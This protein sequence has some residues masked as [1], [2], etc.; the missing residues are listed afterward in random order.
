MEEQNQELNEMRSESKRAWML[1]AIIVLALAVI[2]LVIWLMMMKTELK[3]LHSEKDYQKWQLERQ[4][5]SIVAEHEE[6]KEAYGQVSDSLAGM[7][8]TFQAQ[9]KEIKDL[10]NYKWEFYKV[11]KKLDRLQVVAQG[12][13]RRMDSIVVVNEQLTQENVEMKEEIK[14]AQR[15]YRNLEEEKGELE[16][17]V[18]EASRLGTYNLTAQPVHLRGSGK[19]VPTDK[20]RR[21]DRVTVC[22]TL[23]E[24]T[25]IPP[26]NRTLYLRIA[27]PDK[28]ILLAGRG[29][30]YTFEHQ[31]ETLQYSMKKDLNYQNEAMDLCVKYNIRES[32]EIQVGLYH[33]DIFDGD[34]NIGHTTFELR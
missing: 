33:V 18:D 4:L 8:S 11:Q 30:K 16:E 31:G 29:D 6:V 2:G 22:F 32:Q 25:I 34:N 5:D 12:Y 23:S 7:D 24:N 19:E 27:R 21:L 13:V 1:V 17:K 28:E 9:A 14:I 20:I 3:E 26:G 15:N 10:L